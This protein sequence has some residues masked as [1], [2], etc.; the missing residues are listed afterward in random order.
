MRNFKAIGVHPKTHRSV[1]SKEIKGFAAH[2]NSSSSR[3]KAKMISLPRR[4]TSRKNSTNYCK[5]NSDTSL[6]KKSISI[7]STA[8]TYLSTTS[9]A[10]KENDCDFLNEEDNWSN[11]EVKLN[12][13]SHFDALQGVSQTG[14]SSKKKSFIGHD[15]SLP[16]PEL[17]KEENNAVFDSDDDDMTHELNLENLKEKDPS[18]YQFLCEQDEQLL[19]FGQDTDSAPELTLSKDKR[20][21]NSSVSK[22]KTSNA[23]GDA[24]EE[25]GGTAEVTQQSRT[26]GHSPSELGA[27]NTTHQLTEERFSHV[28]DMALIT[29][30]FRGLRLLLACYHRAVQCLRDPLDTAKAFQQRRD[31]MLNLA[32]GNDKK[33]QLVSSSIKRVPHDVFSEKKRSD[34]ATAAAERTKRTL[35]QTGASGS[36]LYPE[37]DAL[38]LHV[39]QTVVSNIATLLHTHARKRKELHSQPPLTASKKKKIDKTTSLPSSQKES[40]IILGEAT[41]PSK[42]IAI[43]SY[44]SWQ[45]LRM[46]LRIFWTDTIALFQDVS[47]HP[48]LMEILLA[49]I[50]NFDV[51]KWVLPFENLRH[52]L[53]KALLTLWSFTESPVLRLNAYVCLRNFCALLLLPEHNLLLSNFNSGKIVVFS[54]EESTLRGLEAYQS[55]VKWLYQYYAMAT[56][57]GVSW[58]NLDTLQVMQNCVVEMLTI[59]EDTAYRVGF[60]SIRQLGFTIRKSCLAISQKSSPG[61]AAIYKQKKIQETFGN[62][63]GWAF[64][65]SL[66]LWCTAIDRLPKLH[67]LAFPLVTILNASLKLNLTALTYFPFSCHILRLLCDMAV[68]TNKFVPIASYIFSLLETLS[69]HWTKVLHKTFQSNGKSIPISMQSKGGASIKKKQ[70][71]PSSSPP[72]VLI[73]P[74]DLDLTLKLSLNQLTLI[75]TLENLFHRLWLLLVDHMGFLSRH[76][77]FPEMALPLLAS[78]KKLIKSMKSVAAQ[79]DLKKLMLWTEQSISIIKAKRFSLDIF[80]IP[81]GKI[82]FFPEKDIPLAVERATLLEKETE[83]QKKTI[84]STRDSSITSE[85]FQSFLLYFFFTQIEQKRQKNA[86]MDETFEKKRLKRHRLKEKKKNMVTSSALDVSHSQ[87][88]SSQAE[89]S[90]VEE[91]AFVSLYIHPRVGYA[92]FSVKGVL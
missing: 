46:V 48:G 53:S 44:T 82:A 64:V 77:S 19:R 55:L 60:L 51:L 84:L 2:S 42:C 11:D 21:S 7:P 68:V 40:A 85:D 92:A 88:E 15:A 13:K 27:A 31:L 76:P 56:S 81:F 39:V 91:D 87:K 9:A 12:V 62:V 74:C 10:D 69:F 71:M 45:R 36:L 52:S 67:P 22:R 23:N 79:R 29:A 5:A 38:L 65:R 50:K 70:Q 3:K 72:L 41:H 28:S 37:D 61:K 30:S 16:S 24:N 14:K 35:A 59:D 1:S 63:Y 4:S 17:L 73:K 57:T 58:K 49:Y 25:T 18:F 78:L 90:D 86:W 80:D 26:I 33:R 8:P 89:S 43:S 47:R 83:R 54:K 34:A 66:R 32:N 20:I 6:Q 75:Q